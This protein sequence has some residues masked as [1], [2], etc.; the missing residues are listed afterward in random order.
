MNDI[1][2]AILEQERNKVNSQISLL[3]R[4][5]DFLKRFMSDF[6]D[7]EI[8]K[9][10]YFISCIDHTDTDIDYETIVV[11]TFYNF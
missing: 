7:A 1:S 10:R 3:N 11:N 5:I 6:P 2:M 4:K 9:T 8:E